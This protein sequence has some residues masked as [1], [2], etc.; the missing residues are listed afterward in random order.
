MTTTPL[1][2]QSPPDPKV[3]PPDP[4]PHPP[5]SPESQNPPP[6]TS[7][8][9]SPPLRHLLNETSDLIDS[10]PFS[11]ILT[12]LLDT[13][14]SHLTD[15]VLRCHA[16]KLPPS[17]PPSA[18]GVVDEEIAE[19]HKTRLANI[20]AVVSR[21]AHAIGNG[22][23][24]EYVKAMEGVGEL[25]AFGAV[26]F[27]SF[28]DERREEVEDVSRGEMTEGV[29]REKGEEVGGGVLGGVREGFESVWGMVSGR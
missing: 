14:F 3:S 18:S 16:F 22:V 4:I 26:V 23:P 29:E 1:P 25:E 15:H 17:L 9:I 7:S 21:Q 27:S 8:P 24:N 13:T 28:F 6:T 10:P 2:S 11:H 19:E 5:T 20:L 12:L